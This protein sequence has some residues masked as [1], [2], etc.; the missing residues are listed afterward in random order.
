MDPLIWCEWESD[1][2]GCGNHLLELC[3]HVEP[4][5]TITDQKFYCPDCSRG[6]QE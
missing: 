6:A 3:A 4:G 1:N 5:W 2:A